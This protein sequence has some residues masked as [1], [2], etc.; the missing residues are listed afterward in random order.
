M[1]FVA[2]DVEIA[3]A[4]MTSICQISLAKFKDGQLVEEWSQLI[5]PEDYFD[6]INI[7]IHGITEVDVV[8]A[9][10]FPEVMDELPFHH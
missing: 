4:D 1:E 5:D 2:I 9:P 6:S 3:N 8:S 10:T 7:D